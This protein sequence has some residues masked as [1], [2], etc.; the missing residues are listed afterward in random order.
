[1][2]FLL[3]Q[4][5]SESASRYPHREAIVFRDC[6]ISY[7]ELE[8]ETNKVAHKLL[9]SG[10]EKGARVGI[11]MNRGTDS[12]VAALGILKAGA[13][14][15]PVDPASPTRRVSYII[16]KC[17]IKTLLTL[18][19]KLAQIEKAFPGDSPLERILLMDGID[20]SPAVL[21]SSQLIDGRSVPDDMGERAPVVNVVDSDVAYILFTSGS[22]GNP[23]GV[24]LSHLNSLTFINAACGFFGIEKE[25]R[26][27]NI[28]P[29]HFDMSVFDIFVA[30][31]SGACVVVI[32]E[33]TAIFPVKLAEYISEKKITV[34]NSVPS[35]L[36]LLATYKNLNARDL[37][38]LRLIL[39]A[40]ELF[41][42]KYLRILQE[43]LPGARFCNMYG[44]T[45]ANSSTYYWVDRLPSDGAGV[46]PIGKAL[47]NFE[48]FALDENGNRIHNPDQEGE[49][50]VR[51]STV[52]LGYWGEPE[53]TKNSFVSNPLRPDLG[54]KVYK[55]G[56]L[57]RLDSE[58]NY[59]F[60]G[61][62]DHMIKSRGYR[63]EI[64]EIE[65]VLCNHP[66]IKNDVVVPIPDELIGNRL[67]V[68]IVP[69]AP[70]KITKDD[71]LKY[72]YVQLPKYMIPEIIEFRASLPTTSSGKVDRKKLS[73]Q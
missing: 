47:P 9:S 8:W 55:T 61:R 73:A 30:F 17:G 12:I 11:Y 59:V 63:I 7:A 26:L 20:A 67:S 19:D 48:V 29:L 45:E 56:D 49:L 46:L 23:K 43:T 13:A 37:S 70:E 15:V 69:F 35:A 33:T 41:P 38:G 22:T 60:L 24:M 27:S 54:E 14:Y 58:G 32:P 25:D 36:S 10:L 51:A 21:G 68:V 3:H 1:M 44:Q 5:L 39:F 34:W 4:L 72:C 42:L 40:G 66:Q 2:A 18:Q 65:T 53:R 28:A 71:V 16:E 52:A 50:Y 31:K 57:V 6:T 64:G 62:K